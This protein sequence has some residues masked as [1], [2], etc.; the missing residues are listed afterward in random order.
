MRRHLK[1]GYCH[2]VTTGDVMKQVSAISIVFLLL[3][4]TAPLGFAS[5]SGESTSINTFAG[6]FATVDVTLQGNSVNNSTTIDMPRNVTI[7][8]SSFELSVDSNENSPGQVWIDINE[9]GVFEW[10]FTGTGYGDIGHQNQ[11]Y[12]GN[13][14]YVSTMTS[15]NSTSP[16]ILLPSN[17]T[18]QSSSLDVS[19]SPR[20]GGG[21]YAI[22]A[23]QEMIETDID[24]DGNP[25]PMFLSTIQSNNTT[26]VT[27][28]DWNQSSG[29]TM[30]SS[31]QTC[32]NATSITTGDINGDGDDD[33][34][35]FAKDM[36]QACIHMANGSSFDPVLN[37]TVINGLVSAK[38]GDIDGDGAD[39]IVS[40]NSEGNIAFQ[41]WNNS[42]SGLNTAV[43]E[44]IDSNLSGGLDIAATLVE[45]HVGD[46]YGNGNISAL[47]KDATGYWSLWQHFSGMLG[48]PVTTFDDIMR[49]EILIDLDG[50]GDID[51]VGENDEGYAFR[52]NNGTNWNLNLTQN[53]VSMLNSTIADFDKD[54]VLELMTPIPGIS[55]S[56]PL[57]VEGRISLRTINGTNISSALMTG[58]Q[59]WSIPTSI[60]TMDMGGDGVLEHVVSAGESN[61]GVFIGGWHSIELDAN[62]DGN[63]EMSREGYA[64]DSSNNLSPLSMTDDSDKVRDSFSQRINTEPTTVDGYGISMVNLTMDVMSSGDGSFNYSNLDIGYDCSFLVDVN[65]HVIVN[66]TNSLNQQMTGGVGNFTIKIPVNSTK[67]GVI[68]LT[69]IAAVMIP[70]APNLSIPITPVLRLDILTTDMIAFSWN[71]TIE[72]GEDFIDFEIFRLESAS[73]TLDLN[74]VYNRTFTNETRDTNITIGSTYWYVVRSTHQYG[75]ASNLSDIL[76]VT[77]PYPAPPSALTGLSLTDV[78]NDTGG[79]LEL[80][81]NHSQDQFSNYEVYL[82]TSQFSNI[83][84]LT[85]IQTIPSTNNTTVIS[86]LIDGQEYWAAVV[87]VDQYGN[88]S[89]EVTSVGPAY[90][91][92]DV[93]SAI[94]LQ[95]SVS[96][97]TS[98]GSPFFLELTAEIN[99]SQVT[100]SG[101]ILI[102]METSEGVFPIS[103]NWESI[104]LTDFSELVSYASNISGEVTFWA[105][106]SGHEGDAQN[107]PIAAAYTSATTLVTVD[108]V[109]SLSEDYYELDWDNETSVRVNLNALN[110]NQQHLMEG[111]S[112]TW[113]AYNNTTGSNNSGSGIIETGFD[114]FFVT[115]SEEGVLFINLTGPTWIDATTN[116]IQVPLVLYGSV[117]DNNSSNNNDTNTTEWSPTVMLDVTMDCGEIVIE[118]GVDGLIEC[119]ITNP[120]NYSVDILF[121]PDGWSDWDQYI[122]FGPV[123]GQE[124]ISLGEN[125]S[126]VIEIR[127]VVSDEL[128]NIGVKN[129]LIQIDLRQGP[130]DY[131]T[132][133]EEP[134]TIEIQWNLKEENIVIEP[135]PSD[136]NTNKTVATNDEASSD[137]TMLIIGGV[138]ALA[139]IAL[140]VIIVL[141]IRN[142]DLEDW[143]EDDLDMEPEVEVQARES[144]PLPVGVALD[145]FEDKTIVDD[146]PDRPDVI[147][148][149]EEDDYEEESY[150][151]QE[152]TS[153]E[154]Y[155]EY[156]DDTEDDSGISIDE[157]GT[158]WYEDEVG[159]WWYRE[160]GQ[161]D[162][163][164]FVDE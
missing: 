42:T 118:I 92:N 14:W 138:G 5:A 160:E 135:E 106:Y 122:E 152:T 96:P 111:A 98:I 68:S 134:L 91:R 116:S 130:T 102:S 133:L 4:S 25:E 18:L 82:H 9:D 62:G 72:Y 107:Q 146:S 11:F 43:T 16:G 87:A 10:E 95:L 77:V 21:F 115:F 33:I 7:I 112:F 61:L 89:T 110:T 56:N 124:S 49:N 155:E 162:W 105:N 141:R 28:A 53:Q 131:S 120:N 23:F 3:L 90:P 94:N 97:Q 54:G 129:G 100:P 109:L 147:N 132:P 8:T 151:S 140:L 37:S 60:L 29:T 114:Q 20:V 2:T 80:S 32:N 15:G 65:P 136:N 46:F 52:I 63:P 81:W 154:A 86:N 58:L 101:D 70:G 19:F 119:T 123:P 126:K 143:D 35:V 67:A 71:D 34:V 150:E 41:S 48:G 31:L 99:G 1:E 44:R 142:S 66:L 13:E 93:P 137:N 36:D 79:V 47:V 39:D 73:E 55:D 163:S 127:E 149:F 26:S 57:T 161:E 104:N 153:E 38:L 158:E 139:V 128:E 30:S 84:G 88:A 164:E 148:D 121:V 83:S 51:V 144:R 24:G 78:G 159:V 6:G 157:H 75:I 125:E 108:A 45:L 64:G 117:V 12:D 50:D 103:T 145:E 74:N 17:A 113:T 22:G 76:Q 27:W 85:S 59:P 69:N 40:I 156:E